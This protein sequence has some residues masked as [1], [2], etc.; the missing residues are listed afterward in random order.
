VVGAIKR[1]AGDSVS[2]GPL[3]AGPAGA[4]V[5]T[6]RGTI[7][8]PIADE[9]KPNPLTYAVRLP[10]SLSIEVRVGAVGRFGAEG[11]IE[12]R[13]GVRTVNP[14]AILID[15]EPVHPSDV[16]F[17]IEARGVQSKLLQRAGD[18][19]GELRQHAARYVN[20]QTS[21]PEAARF[22]RIELLPLIEASWNSL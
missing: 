13:L 12:L 17:A 14:L 22:M 6:A 10:V 20:E 18:V 4:A 21:R 11:E 1:V 9:I 5:V 19:E 16:R 7:G 2:L 8:E 15:V 3:R